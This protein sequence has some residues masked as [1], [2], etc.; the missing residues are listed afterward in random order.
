MYDEQIYTHERGNTLTLI[1]IHGRESDGKGGSKDV[2]HFCA[3]HQSSDGLIFNT[4]LLCEEDAETVIQTY[5]A[6]GYKLPHS[7]TQSVAV[8]SVDFDFEPAPGSDLTLQE[9]EDLSEYL[10]RKRPPTLPTA[11]RRSA[12]IELDNQDPPKEDYK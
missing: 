9:L 4:Q 12:F 11:P 3:V 6:R 1:C 10:D 2:V 8:L 7:D 5:I